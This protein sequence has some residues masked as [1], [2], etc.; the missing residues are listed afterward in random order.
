MTL[1]EI[2]SKYLEPGFEHDSSLSNELYRI[3][4]RE[5]PI[6]GFRRL[7]TAKSDVAIGAAGFF[8]NE[9]GYKMH[10]FVKEI[11]DLLDHKS[12]QIRFDAILGLRDCTTQ[13]DGEALGR[14]LLLLD[15]PDPFV[16]RGVMK[17]IQYSERWQLRAA[18]LRAAKLRPG[19]VFEEFRAEAGRFS[20]ITARKVRKFIEHPDAIARRFGVGLAVRPREVVDERFLKIAERCND[21]EGLLTLQQARK[22]ISPTNAVW[23]SSIVNGPGGQ[24]PEP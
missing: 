1:D 11:T 16:H 6:E 9:F 12:P 8:V 10:S 7:L 15:D 18:V 21:E 2:V 19:T 20:P 17:F 23:L 3:L 13:A 22:Y 4:H 5:F 14:V 24:S